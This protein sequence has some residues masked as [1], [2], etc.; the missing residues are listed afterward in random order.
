MEWINLIEDREQWWAVTN[1]VIYAL[2]V[3]ISH[4]G[5]VFSGSIKCGEFVDFHLLKA[6]AMECVCNGYLELFGLCSVQYFIIFPYP[7]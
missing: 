4:N 3:R 2:V 1:A 6:P 5:N 7:F